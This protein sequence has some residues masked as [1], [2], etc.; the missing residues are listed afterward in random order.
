MTFITCSKAFIAEFNRWGGEQC[1]IYSKQILIK[2]TSDPTELA[3]QSLQTA[4]LQF[5]IS[6]ELYTFNT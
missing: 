5:C 6:Y 1:V 3:L 4:K 2:F